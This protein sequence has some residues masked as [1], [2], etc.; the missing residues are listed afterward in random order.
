MNYCHMRFTVPAVNIN[1][2]SK[3]TLK[4]EW[5]SAMATWH[6]DL[7][8]SRSCADRTVNSMQQQSRQLQNIMNKIEVFSHR[9]VRVCCLRSRWSSNPKA[10]SLASLTIYRYSRNILQKTWIISTVC[11]VARWI[12]R[13]KHTL[14]WLLSGLW[15]RLSVGKYT[16]FLWWSSCRIIQLKNWRQQAPQKRWY[17]HTILHSVTS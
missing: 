9:F 2:H 11:N 14:N 8:S 17:R 5:I 15:V 12:K 6:H 16:N 13:G 3:I 10:A 1:S 7:T 4:K